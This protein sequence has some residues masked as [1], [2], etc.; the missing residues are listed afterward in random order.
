MHYDF[1]DQYHYRP[2]VVHE[3]DPRVKVVLALSTILTISLCAE[4]AWTAFGL[5]FL[6]LL[7]AG[8]TS[9]LG[10]LYA[11]RRSYIAL[12]F[13]LAA[14]AVPFTV[15]GEVLGKL[16]ILG[17]RVS[18]PGLVRFFSVLMRSWLAVQVAIL[19]TAT[20]RFPDLLWAMGALRVPG[21]LV[22]TVG[23]M[24]RYLFVLA[25]E[26]N[27]M[28][29]ARGARSVSTPEGQ[30][31][32]VVWQG[33]VAG[34]MAGSLFLRA[35]ERSERIYNAML[36]RGYDGRMISIQSFHMRHRDWGVLLVA[37]AILS[38]MLVISRMG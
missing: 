9:Q 14:L 13:M 24:Y 25:D 20:T 27:R 34:A 18:A 21:A 12:P 17:W 35:L 36:A 7:F 6:S 11:V 33:K 22:S 2:S 5:V 10:P 28:L 16:P 8:W 19:L 1:T 32:S 26:A 30:R 29:R 38:L 3:L 37:A 31:P 23:F 15:P 4:G